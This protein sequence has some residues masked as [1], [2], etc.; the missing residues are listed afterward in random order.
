MPIFCIGDRKGARLENRIRQFTEE[1]TLVSISEGLQLNVATAGRGESP[2][3]FVPG[4]SLSLDV[5]E[6]QFIHFANSTSIRFFSFDPRG[7]GQSTKV[8]DDLSAAAR[9]VDI[10][11]LLECLKLQD[12][13]LGGWSQGVHDV[14]A[15][16]EQFGTDRL[17]ALVLI[18]GAP[19]AM[20]DDNVVE[21]AWY[22]RDDADGYR[23]SLTKALL[24]NPP[25]AYKRF[26]A[27]MLESTDPEA[28]DWLV[29]QMQ[30]M[31][32]MIGALSIEQGLDGNYVNT[33]RGLAGKI[34]ILIVVSDQKRAAAQL[35][36]ETNIPQAF[37]V[38]MGKHMM[39]WERSRHFNSALDQFLGTLSS[40]AT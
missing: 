5:F 3:L 4:W 17:R 18:D 13:V 2:V 22:R 26:A 10:A 6:R 1:P 16:V 15:Y 27:S 14:L 23:N 38:S 21:W 40:G 29:S 31:P 30:Q 12:V 34:P 35:W 7:Q 33:L 36:V 11:G 39:F 37:I 24:R 32:P 25:G 8:A 28:V 9:G 20:A 19:M